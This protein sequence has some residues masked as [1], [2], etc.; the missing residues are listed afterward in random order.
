MNFSPPGKL[1]LEVWGWAQDF[2]PCTQSEVEVW[3]RVL[4]TVQGALD[5]LVLVL[6]VCEMDRACLQME[7]SPVAPRPSGTTNP[8]VLEAIAALPP[9]WDTPSSSQ[10]PVV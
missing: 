4:V 8:K 6:A 1:S 10:S 2:F 9:L 5:L 3:T 7:M